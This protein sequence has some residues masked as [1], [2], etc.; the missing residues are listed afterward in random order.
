[1]WRLVH[2]ASAALCPCATAGNGYCRSAHQAQL[3]ELSPAQ[4]GDIWF[5][6]IAPYYLL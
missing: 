3:D 1:V 6:H 4:F 5:V 2:K